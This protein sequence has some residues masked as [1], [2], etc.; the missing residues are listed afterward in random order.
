MG[1]TRQLIA[2]RRLGGE[3]FER[4]Q[5]LQELLLHLVGAI[6]PVGQFVNEVRG[7]STLRITLSGDILDLL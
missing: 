7:R 4:Q 6:D 5:L 2:T 1:H 3:P